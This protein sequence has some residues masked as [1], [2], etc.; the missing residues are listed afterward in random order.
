MKVTKEQLHAVTETL[1]DELPD[2]DGAL[3]AVN[4]ANLTRFVLSVGEQ[5]RY[6]LAVTH[7]F[8]AVYQTANAI[9]SELETRFV[10]RELR[11]T[12]PTARSS[13][14][15]PGTEPRHD[16]ILPHRCRR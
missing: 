6:R 1:S 4:E 10:A 14:L 11:D 2:T 12:R 9:I 8:F 15:R 5:Q 13:V 3:C 16:D 7:E